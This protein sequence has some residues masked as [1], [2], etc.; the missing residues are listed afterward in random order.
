MQCPK[1]QKQNLPEARYCGQCGQVLPDPETLE[2][3]TLK[4]S[5]SWKEQ[6]PLIGFTVGSIVGFII[7]DI[8]GAA[9]GAVLGGAFS[10]FIGPHIKIRGRKGRKWD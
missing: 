8:V 6:N 9:I 1:C 3:P 5:R 4:G 7:G 10:V 2:S